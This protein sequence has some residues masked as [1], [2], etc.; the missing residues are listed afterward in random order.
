MTTTTP[1][2]AKI[3]RPQPK[4]QNVHIP[5]YGGLSLMGQVMIFNGVIH[6]ATVIGLI[7]LMFRTGWSW[8]M[9]IIAAVAADI[10]FG[11]FLSG[12]L[13]L[14]FRDIARNTANLNRLGRR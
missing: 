10:A 6:G 3:A 4:Q 8:W 13:V 14:C 9:I 11:S 12:L 7:V 1:P 2:M 5:D